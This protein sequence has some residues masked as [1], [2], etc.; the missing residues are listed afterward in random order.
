MAKTF[1]LFSQRNVHTK[2]CRPLSDNVGGTNDSGEKE[3]EPMQK[4]HKLKS[5]QNLTDTG[6]YAISFSAMLAVSRGRALGSWF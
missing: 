6:T 1:Y 4:L 3:S 2:H 5:K